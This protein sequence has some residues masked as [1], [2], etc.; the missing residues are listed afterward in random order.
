MLT[1]RKSAA[2]AGTLTLLACAVAGFPAASAH[3][4][5]AQSVAQEVRGLDLTQLG[6]IEVPAA[7]Q[8]SKG[9]GVTVGVLDTGA[10]ATDPDLT[11]S[12]TT[13]PDYTAGADPAGYQ[14]P[15]LHG[16]YISSLIAG[17]GSGPGDSEGMLGVA[18]DAKVLS[19]RVILD[20]SE[21]GLSVFESSP[22]YQN[23]VADGID[24]AVNHGVRVINM[25]LGSTSPIR[26]LRTAIAYA[27]AHGVVVIASAGNSGSAG[28]AY[29]PY[30]YPASFTGVIAVAAVNTNGTRASFSDDNASVVLSAP[31]V[32]VV[33]AGPGGEYIEADGTSPA[34]AFVSGVAALI[35][36]KYPSLSPA[37]VEQALVT[38]TTHRPAGGYSPSVGFGEVDASAAL[39]A[40]AK[41]AV[42]PT[43]AGLAA[44]ARLSS[45]TVP[46]IQVTHR[47][48]ARI[49]GYGAAAG[50]AALGF[51]VALILL[52]TW[53][54]R[55]ARDRREA[56]YGGSAPGDAPYPYP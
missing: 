16:T 37:L 43:Q 10:D 19:V 4:T 14:P 26:S 49:R 6:Q 32:N 29:T 3:A 41:L 18:P 47:D 53:A 17:H 31:G 56:R 12:V 35:R 8:L 24:Y 54:V 39:A 11:G 22:R 40:A 52:I 27:V 50:V 13:G 33:G 20:D 46:A 25:S 44:T 15:Y 45:G 28:S 2:A 48:Q 21:P 55:A 30:D 42:T 38:S 9:A 1:R 7:W 51:L 36:S 5:T 23:S 34:A